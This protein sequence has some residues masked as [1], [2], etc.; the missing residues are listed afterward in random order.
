MMALL[1]AAGVSQARQGEGAR[2]GTDRAPV[3]EPIDP[4]AAPL[5]SEGYRPPARLLV[6]EGAFLRNRRGRLV[7]AEGM[8]FY[9]FDRDA[10]GLAEP[11]MVMQPSVRLREMQRLV[12][13]SQNTITFST[14][15]QVFVYQGRNYFLPTYF[16]VMS[17]EA[18]PASMTTGEAAPA[19]QAQAGARGSAPAAAA[20]D[21]SVQQLLDEMKSGPA[22]IVRPAPP[23]A[24]SA[25]RA[26]GASP[27][28]AGAP[29]GKA[30]PE[31]QSLLREGLAIVSRRGRIERSGSG[32]LV[33]MTD[34]GAAGGVG[35]AGGAGVG[36]NDPPLHLMPCLNLEAIE[37]LLQ[38]RGERLMFV[39]SG[40]V[41]AFDDKNY[42]LPTF[43][44]IEP[45]REGNIVPAQ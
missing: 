11:P 42:L 17:A 29:A 25:P 26:G 10:Q 23:P 30:D 36:T 6:R 39:M 28:P 41:L 13:T 35:V 45:D 8:W 1:C 2:P 37:T 34:N 21:P 15:G 20:V 44:R 5:Q 38:T 12:T 3:L 40:R 18:P 33:F 16:G 24:T 9:V 43:Y 14:T 31:N 22:P 7:Q 19:G 27:D 4:R 32:G